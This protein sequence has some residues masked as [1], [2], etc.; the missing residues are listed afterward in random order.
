MIFAFMALFSMAQTPTLL[1]VDIDT[2]TITTHSFYIPAQA[3]GGGGTWYVEPQVKEINTNILI[4]GDTTMYTGTGMSFSVMKDS[5]LANTDYLPRLVV[6]NSAF[7]QVAIVDDYPIVRTKPNAMPVT[8]G[9][10]F[11]APM[12]PNSGLQFTGSSS[13]GQQA[14]ALGYPTAGGAP[15]T[16]TIHFGFTNSF[17]S[18]LMFLVDSPN[19]FHPSTRVVIQGLSDGSVA[20]SAI[21][22]A[23]STPTYTA[24][25]MTIGTPVVTKDSVFTNINITSLGNGGNPTLHVIITDTLGPNV[26]Q[27]Q[28]VVTT[29]GPIGIPKGSLLSN[30]YYRITAT[31]ITPV[32][33]TTVS[34]KVF[35]TL[36]VDPA[37]VTVSQQMP[38]DYI[39]YTTKSF[40]NTK[41]SG[42]SSQVV[43]AEL[44]ENNVVVNSTVLALTD[45]GTIT[46]TQTGQTSGTSKS[47]KVRVTNG[48]NLVT[49]SSAV[50]VSML[51]V[52]QPIM[53]PTASVKTIDSIYVGFNVTS[54]GIPLNPTFHVVIK[55][56]LGDTILNNT[57]LVTSTGIIGIG[58]GGLV[59]NNTFT[60]SATLAN[61]LMFG[62]TEIVVIT[63]KNVNPAS[64]TPVITTTY[65][66]YTIAATI[67]QNGTY[68]S[69]AIQKVRLLE[70][71]VAIDSVMGNTA[72]AN[73]HIYQRIP[74][75]TYHGKI[76]VTNL[77]N[78]VYTTNQFNIVMKTILPDGAPAYTNIFRDDAQT[79]RFTGITYNVSNGNIAM[80]RFIRRDQM[81]GIVDTFTAIYAATGVGSMASFSITNCIG[82]H[83]YVFTIIDESQN[84]IVV[85]TISPPTHMPSPENPI[86]ETA[87]LT[88]DIPTT[89]A[90]S[91]GTKIFGS[92]EGNM[93][94]M[95]L[96]LATM[97]NNPKGTFT[98]PIAGTFDY[99]HVWTG[100][101]PDTWYVLTAQLSVQDGSFTTTPV[102]RSFKTDA[103]T[104]IQEIVSSVPQNDVL[105]HP[106]NAIAQELA[107]VGAYQKTFQGLLGCNQLVFFQILDKDGLVTGKVFKT[108][109]H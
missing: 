105:V 19:Y 18:T 22:P 38:Q 85:G 43:Y 39:S 4:P 90:Y 58:K 76:E 81:T 6:Y 54:L 35:K 31:A 64:A 82:D 1:S 26:F 5:L 95:F 67:N 60:I 65:T 108:F 14:F 59:S 72:L 24:T 71:G 28:Q 57:R 29:T 84:G 61:T 12:L 23:F 13:V 46:F 74:G 68:D 3:F 66:D 89:T 52:G 45:T 37:T 63:T 55:N 77:A 49:T 96:S 62:D 20:S 98:T 11:A 27:F 8:I 36:N 79:V 34:T 9:S 94:D 48:A 101:D 92:T 106:Y 51:T 7:V 33:M 97:N 42:D 56:Q 40:I 17:S 104:G 53:N 83:T 87:G 80:I 25:T 91:L 30:H 41:G 100:L 44:L 78:L 99:L 75:R 73:F 50:N 103:A 15:V 69:S 16:D 70:D 93:C 86:L 107:P 102:S 109:I 32:N 88:Q 10:A 21:I 47:V 2:N